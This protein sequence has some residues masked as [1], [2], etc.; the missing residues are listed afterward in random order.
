MNTADL[1]NEFLIEQYGESHQLVKEIIRLRVKA[2]LENRV[3]DRYSLATLPGVL[4]CNKSSARVVNDL[5]KDRNELQ[6][7]VVE[8][9]TLVDVRQKWE[10]KT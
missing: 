6:T 3:C 5:L 8:L 1:S 4:F 7:L 9:R 2:A 10:S